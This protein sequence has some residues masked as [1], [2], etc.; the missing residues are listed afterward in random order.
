MNSSNKKTYLL[1]QPYNI[2]KSIHEI[3]LYL[4][5][6]KKDNQT[7]FSFDNVM[8]KNIHTIFK[9]TSKNTIELL[10]TLSEW[11]INF[12]LNEIEKICA[13]QRS[14]IQFEVYF[15]R[16]STR[17]LYN[18]FT[19]IITINSELIIYHRIPVSYTHLDVYKRQAKNERIW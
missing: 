2:G 11:N 16:A 6:I 13:K 1:I 9:N 4:H 8:S 14:C 7:F 10:K 5:L 17:L 3:F 15:E 19:N 12:E 18:L